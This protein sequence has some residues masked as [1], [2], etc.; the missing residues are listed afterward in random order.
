MYRI[1]VKDKK[2]WRANSVKFAPEGGGPCLTMRLEGLKKNLR[3][4]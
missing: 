3:A 4:L 1:I 2:S